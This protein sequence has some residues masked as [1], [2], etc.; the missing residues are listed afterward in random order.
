MSRRVS[1]KD[2]ESIVERINR[3]TD[4]PLTSYVKSKDGKYTAQIGNY[5]LDGA[6]GGYALHRMHNEGGGIEDVLRVG[7]VSKPELQ[8]LLFAFINGLETKDSK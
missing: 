6:Y 8:R 5:H 2:L 3:I 1:I 4:S 7:H